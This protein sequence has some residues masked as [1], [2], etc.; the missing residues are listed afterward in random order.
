MGRIFGV[1]LLLIPHIV[2]AP[3][4]EHHGTKVPEELQDHFVLVSLI[5]SAAFWLILG[6]LNAFFY[7]RFKIN[8][9]AI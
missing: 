5:T 3:Q 4:P 7:Q 8:G 9:K 2:G 6:S 1:A